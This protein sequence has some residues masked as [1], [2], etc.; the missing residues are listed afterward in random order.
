MLKYFRAI[1]LLEGLSF[2]AILS[3]SFGL[4][5]RDFVYQLGMAHGML[6]MLY[7]FLS[8]IVSNKQQWSLLTWLSLFVASIVPFAFIGVEIFLSRTAGN[9]K[10]AEA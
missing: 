5:S 2:L 10:L 9:Q 1:S 6:F 7:L 4:V 8:L 3:I